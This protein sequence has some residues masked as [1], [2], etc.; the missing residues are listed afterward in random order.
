MTWSPD[1]AIT[2]AAQ[3]NFTSPTYTWANDVAPDTNARQYVVTAYGGTQAS[4]RAH[5]AGDPFTVTIRRSP[6]KALPQKNSQGVYG[7][8]PLNRVEILA[9][10]GVYIDS[11]SNVR[12]A[13]LRLIAEI[14][15][16]S[17]LADAPNIRALVSN[18]LGVLSEESADYGDTLITAII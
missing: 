9:R 10:K 4:V 2:G 3:T 1:L 15:A 5:T 6:Y 7:N 12:V 13:N 16:G 11:A 17:E 14:P 18:M 8:V